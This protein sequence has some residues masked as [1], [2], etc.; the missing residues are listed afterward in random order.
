MTLSGRVALVTGGASGIGE[1]LVRR[2]ADEGAQTVVVDVDELGAR[3]VADEVGGTAI[4]ADVSRGSDWDEIAERLE[5]LDVACLNAGVTTG[6]SS[7]VAVTDEQYERILGVN[8]DGVVYGLRAL[9]PLLEPESGAV[10]VTASLA[11]L[12][13]VPEDPLYAATKHFVVGLVRSVAPELASRGVRVN[14]V[15]PGYTDTPLVDGDE[16]ARFAALELP[17]L[18]PEEVADAALAALVSGDSGEAWIC[19]PGRQPEPYRFRGVPGPRVLDA[20]SF[21]RPAAP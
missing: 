4:A 6:T 11:G 19:Q 21:T 8:V 18:R 15:C 7:V 20:D 10:V 16:R 5:R 14:A 12:T 2:L 9:V 17:L 3:R 13:A 1:A